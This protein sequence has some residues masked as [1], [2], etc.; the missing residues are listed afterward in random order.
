MPE[1]VACIQAMSSD[2]TIS[3]HFGL[4]GTETQLTSRGPWDYLSYF[5]TKQLS[6]LPERFE[7]DKIFDRM[8]CDLEQFFYS[9]NIGVRE[10]SPLHN[11]SSDVDEIDSGD[12]LRI[13]KIT[14]SELE[15]LV[16]LKYA[17]ELTHQTKKLLG[18]PPGL[19]IGKTTTAADRVSSPNI[20]SII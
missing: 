15:L 12:G 3:K 14:T 10:F 1:Y 4:V 19:P 16:H 13:R 20:A 7:F 9:E 18:G 6:Q 11:F 8:Y 17:M 2:A 5:L